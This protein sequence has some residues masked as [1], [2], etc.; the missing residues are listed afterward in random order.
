[1]SGLDPHIIRKDFPIL[2]QTI[3]GKPLIYFDNAATSQSP[4]QVMEASTHYYSHINSNIHRAAHKLAREATAAHEAA[5]ETIST[6]LNCAHAH[7]LIFTSGTTDSINLVSNTL[8]LSGK[9][10]AGDKIIISALEH[11][12][13]IVPWQMLCQR[14]GA[15]LEIIPIHEDGTFD[16]DAYEGMLDESVKLVAISHVSNALG[17]VNPVSTIISMAK[18]HDALVLVDGAQ[19]AP[20]FK[21]DV[22]ELNC[23]FYVFSGHKIYGP[24]GIGILYGKEQILNELP[25]WRGGGEMIKEVTFEHTTYND[26]PFK[27]EAGTPDIEGAIAMAAA[28]DYMNAIGLE[29]IAAHESYLEQKTTAALKE[30]NGIKLYGTAPQKAAVV[31][32]RIEGIHHYDLGTLLDQMGVAVRTGHHCCQPLMAR[33]G[34]TGT[35]RASF[36]AYNTEQ[37]VDAFIE[38]IHK[39]TR[40]LS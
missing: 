20:H 6:H 3:N 22:Q 1:M 7:E 29:K 21:I 24:T 10:S 19:A 30:I 8:A 33:Y 4:R 25:P 28:I 9:I 36:A 16:M 38:A 35:V 27:F 12:A 17:T 32:F 37:E 5:R 13:N 11:H 2:D 31:S 40:M 23:D 26:L 34:I 18:Q 39:A 14:T 15:S